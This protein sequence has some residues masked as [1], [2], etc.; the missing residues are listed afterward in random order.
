MSQLIQIIFSILI[1]TLYGII[2][3]IIFKRKLM[4]LIIS[5]ILTTIYIYLI[6]KLNNGIINITLKLSLIFG[7]IIYK[8]MS[9]FKKSM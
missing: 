4:T 5:L 9:N 6:Y 2:S 7:F 8:Y 1:G 3:N